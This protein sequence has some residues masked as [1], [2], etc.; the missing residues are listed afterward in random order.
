[1]N[2][3]WLAIH[4]FS[5]YHLT[6]T[7]NLVFVKHIGHRYHFHDGAEG[8][9][10][11]L[12]AASMVFLQGRCVLVYVA[13]QRSLVLHQV[14]KS[15][16]RPIGAIIA[17]YLTNAVFQETTRRQDFWDML[18]L[19]PFQPLVMDIGVNLDSY[20]VYKHVFVL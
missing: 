3:K 11:A 4:R 12:I 20:V 10:L 1:M 2:R 6:K 7:D 16:R 19:H 13:V 18:F 17:Q 15:I 8:H 5:F 14:L 9:K